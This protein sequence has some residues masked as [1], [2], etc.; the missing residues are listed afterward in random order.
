[1]VW[2]R[3]RFRAFP[4]LSRILGWL[5]QRCPLTPAPDPGRC[6]SAPQTVQWFAAAPNFWG[7]APQ[8]C[9]T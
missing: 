9:A 7:R 1:M 4:A 6:K 5:P 2:I 8:A 3:P